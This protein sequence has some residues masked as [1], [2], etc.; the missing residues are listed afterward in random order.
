MSLL[1]QFYPSSSGGNG[2]TSIGYVSGYPYLDT[3]LENIFSAAYNPTTGWYYI[4]TGLSR[5]DING[6][7]TQGG[8]ILASRDGENFTL[9]YAANLIANGYGKSYNFPLGTPSG[10][11]N[12][13]VVLAQSISQQPGSYG[14]L[15]ATL[16]GGS[17]AGP[18]S[19]TPK[20]PA[21]GAMMNAPALASYNSNSGRYLIVGN[22]AGTYKQTTSTDGATWSA[23]ANA[24]GTVPVGTLTAYAARGRQTTYINIDASTA[25]YKTTD[26]GL[27]WTAVG[28]TLPVTG[29]LAA[30]A[31]NT[32]NLALAKG[33]YSTNEGVSWQPWSAPAGVT[34]LSSIAYSDK[35]DRYIGWASTALNSS[36]AGKM[37]VSTDGTGSTW[38]YAAAGDTELQ[39]QLWG[40][41][42]TRN[43]A[44]GLGTDLY[45]IP[46]S[47]AS[48]F[49]SSAYIAKVDVSLL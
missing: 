47:A 16:D 14:Y 21:A 3:N 2:S 36:V 26:G 8:N 48:G 28:G 29:P 43:A 42:L 9:G 41:T 33:Y 25:L 38:V 35:A 27:A 15:V 12:D 30:G 31:E 11:N 1:T 5:D 10:A 22:D 32:G 45:Y 17:D 39:A 20:S 18:V 13:A 4:V 34:E 37:V 19:F 24:G 40:L 6:Y 23:I 49:S 7:Q 46:Q 44:I